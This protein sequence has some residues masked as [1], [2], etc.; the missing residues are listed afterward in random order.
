M[1]QSEYPN[2]HSVCWTWVYYKIHKEDAAADDVERDSQRGMEERRYFVV[3]NMEKV[4][5]N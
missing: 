2:A 3:N 5:T 4:S 1:P